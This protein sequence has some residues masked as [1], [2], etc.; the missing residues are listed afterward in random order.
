MYPKIHAEQ[1]PDGIAVV[2]AESGATVTW[3]ELD[4]RSN[5][6]AHLF[7][8]RGLRPGDAIAFSLEN[9]ERF[10]EVVWAAQR[11]GLRY[12]PINSRLT[13]DETAYIVEDCGARAFIA[14][15]R[16]PDLVAALAAE[17]P[18]VEVRLV[19]GGP[20]P[21]GWEPYE[22]AVAT[23]PTTP[24]ATE[25]EGVDMLYS[26]GTT[27]RPK[28]V[29][30]P[31]S[32]AAAGTPDNAVFLVRDVFGCDG[33]SVF[34]S[35]APLYH[36][37]PLILS[38][39]VHRLGGT[40]VVM[41]RFD[42]RAALALIERYQVSHSQ[43]VPT[44]FVRL[45]KLDPDQRDRHDLSSHRL[46]IHGAGPC[47]V[48]VKQRMIDWWGPIL[49][50]YYSGTEGAG[51]CAITSDEWLEHRGSVGRPV[52]GALHIVR[53]DGS[54]CA[55][56]EV[57]TVYFEG[58]PAFEYHNDPD[59]TASS[60]SDRGWTT[61]GDLG[62]VDDDGYLYLTD[63]QAFVIV[64]GGV[65]IY[66]QEIEDV[67]VLHPDVAD[68]A[69]FGVPNDDLVEETKAVV[70]PADPAMAGPELARELIAHCRAH[71]ASYKCP[72]S[73]DFLAELPRAETG[74]LAKRALRDSYWAPETAARR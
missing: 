74:K 47:P 27:G 11:S 62:Y 8:E 20:C 16:R 41:E 42:P 36:G 28:G 53:D 38:M 48:E 49:Y 57:G 51:V 68:V 32:G 66:P 43:W 65:N 60:R 5:R 61:L 50:D 59:K 46:A 35:T 25:L 40:V 22:S 17:L 39:A 33:D 14:S 19:L 67:L 2:M 31:L 24:L 37:A 72:R 69:V 9:T 15:G 4:E 54:E 34:L 23:Q 10:F 70:Q 73:I 52:L 58:G 56:G 13:A 44:M 71:L 1:N 45:L 12:T 3:R 63:R 7:D 18:A 64:S 26:S 6:L 55:A 29:K 30:R 21:D